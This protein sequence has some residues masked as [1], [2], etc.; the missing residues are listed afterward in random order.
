MFFLWTAVHFLALSLS[1]KPI[2]LWVY[3]LL[4]VSC[5]TKISACPLHF[6]E[7]VGLMACQ[8]IKGKIRE[9]F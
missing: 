2:D 4:V 1:A 8:E 7:D 6:C 5:Q 3:A 9:K